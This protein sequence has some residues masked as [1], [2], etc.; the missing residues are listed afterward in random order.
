MTWVPISSGSDDPEE[1]IRGPHKVGGWDPENTGGATPLI[2]EPSGVSLAHY[3]EKRLPE[4]EADAAAPYGINDAVGGNDSGVALAHIEAKS[5][6]IYIQHAQA[7]GESEFAGLQPVAELLGETLEDENRAE[8]N[9]NFG[10]L[11]DSSMAEIL[12]AFKE[13]E[14]GEVFEEEILKKFASMIGGMTADQ[15]DAAIEAWKSER[16]E[17]KKREQE[18]E[19]ALFDSEGELRRAQTD[20]TEAEAK[21]LPFAANPDSAGKP[22]ERP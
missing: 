8:W 22:K 10:T 3:T 13:A 17:Q 11:S 14:P 20:K 2:L 15:V 16:E 4:L 9:M 6:T 5:T 21:N 1:T 18:Q 12:T 7:G 19:D